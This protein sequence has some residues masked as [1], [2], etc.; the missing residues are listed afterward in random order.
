MKISE[1]TLN[2]LKNYANIN[3]NLVVQPGNVISTSSPLKTIAAR[4]EVEENF[5]TNFAI[6]ELPKFLGV[7]SLFASPEFDFGEKQVTISAGKQKT[8]YTYADPSL[9][10]QPPKNGIPWPDM[11]SVDFDLT[12]VDLNK[13]LK[14]LSVLQ[15][16]E[17]A[18]IGNGSD[19][20]IE[21]INSK[22]STADKFS[23]DVGSTDVKFTTVIKAEYLKLMQK[24]YKVSISAKGLIKFEA[25]N[26][27]Y[28]VV[29][30]SSSK[31][32]E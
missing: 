25:P 8:K 7:V 14:A 32:G 26:L 12:A 15:L 29:A 2:I 16:P 24:D 22:N 9:I 1:P 21:A 5:P 3:T 27:T 19:I 18:F 23:V 30:E 10:V 28:W 4:A 20:S 11:P 13:T 6:W 31:F 17:I